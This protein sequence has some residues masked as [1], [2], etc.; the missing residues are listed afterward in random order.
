MY[1]EIPRDGFLGANESVP[2]LR[3]VWRSDA[4]ASVVRTACN[5]GGV[6]RSPAVQN[7]SFP[8]IMDAG[9]VPVEL[10]R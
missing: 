7:G 5:P 9:H 10:S 6:G 4:L 1:A 2:A 3:D 8:T